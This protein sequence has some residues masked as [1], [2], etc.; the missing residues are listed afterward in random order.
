MVNIYKTNMNLLVGETIQQLNSKVLYFSTK[1]GRDLSNEWEELNS[2][3]IELNYVEGK[4]ANMMETPIVEGI[5]E[6]IS[7][8]II[9]V[10][11]PEAIK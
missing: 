11:T 4:H 3:N 7:R 2:N 9:K 8:H 5:G 1:E 6:I 10:M